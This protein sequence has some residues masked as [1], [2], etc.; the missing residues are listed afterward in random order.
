MPLVWSISH[1]T[2]SVLVVVRGPLEL[3]H[4]TGL[5][6]TIDRAKAS[7]Y[8]KIIDIRYSRYPSSASTIRS[9]ADIVQK[10]ENDCEVGPIAIVSRLIAARTGALLFAD[11]AQSKRLIKVFAERENARR[12]LDSFYAYGGAKP[13]GLLG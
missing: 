11:L 9:F 2:R 12:W 10:R 6:Q 4:L 1:P 3:P 5:L 13:V 8:R 7:A